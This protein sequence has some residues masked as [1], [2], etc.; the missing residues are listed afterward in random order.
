MLFLFF[1]LSS[2]LCLIYYPLLPFLYSIF[3]II[4]LS[5]I[6]KYIPLSVCTPF[7]PASLPLFLPSFLPSFLLWGATLRRAVATK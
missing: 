3:P 5:F 4:Y 1:Y 2:F 6:I 7:L